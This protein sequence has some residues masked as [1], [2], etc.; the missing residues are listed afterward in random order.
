MITAF[1][2]AIQKS[3]TRARLSVHHASFSWAFCQE[4][5]R[6]TIQR[7]F[8]AIVADFPFWGEI[9]QRRWRTRGLRR[10]AS[11]S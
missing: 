8:A 1:E 9:S 10:T 2:K 4:F 6:S 3:T 7:P 11:G 5:A